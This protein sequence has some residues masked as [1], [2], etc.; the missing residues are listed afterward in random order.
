MIR[1]FRALVALVISFYFPSL[2]MGTY[3]YFN[4]AQNL[5]GYDTGGTSTDYELAALG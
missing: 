1:T 2:C 5:L 3:D 4:Y